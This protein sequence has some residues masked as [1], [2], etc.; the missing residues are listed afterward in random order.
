M[1]TP[2]VRGHAK[3]S[4]L[5]RQAPRFADDLPDPA[6][7]RGHLLVVQTRPQRQGAIRMSDLE[8]YSVIVGGWILIVV[9]IAW[10]RAREGRQK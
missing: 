4:P 10:L 1:S 6:R 8:A 5:P 2:L 7:Y 9:F 3:R